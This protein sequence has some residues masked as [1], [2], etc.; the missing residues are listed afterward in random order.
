MLYEKIFWISNSGIISDKSGI[1]EIS[2]A[3]VKRVNRII[4]LLDPIWNI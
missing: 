2:N 3:T 4:G 1:I